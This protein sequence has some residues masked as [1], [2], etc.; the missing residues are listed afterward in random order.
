MADTKKKKTKG[1]PK[2]PPTAMWDGVLA[3]YSSSSSGDRH[4]SSVGN[5][6]E[7]MENA[8]GSK[9]CELGKVVAAE[10]KVMFLGCRTFS[11]ENARPFKFVYASPGPSQQVLR[12]KRETAKPLSPLSS[13]LSEK[14]VWINKTR[15]AK[16]I[17]LA[18]EKRRVEFEDSAD[19]TLAALRYELQQMEERQN[20]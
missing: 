11:G 2:N 7:K 10:E 9:K 8:K 17:A 14:E 15:A 13:A 3:G 6:T 18:K 4:S 5:L 16:A 19:S 1:G 12:L 20:A